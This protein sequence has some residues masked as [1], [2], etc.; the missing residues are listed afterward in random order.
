ME[1]LRAPA[2]PAHQEIR[3]FV[4]GAIFVVIAIG[5]RSGCPY[6]CRLDLSHPLYLPANRF[7]HEFQYLEAVASG[8]AS[9]A[10]SMTA[11]A[12]IR[13]LTFVSFANL[14]GQHA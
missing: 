14:F 4:T 2:C 12:V 5:R 10:V 7:F 13:K 3:T 8:V 6:W 9:V 1:A 11:K